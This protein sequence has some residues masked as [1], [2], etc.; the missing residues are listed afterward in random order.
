VSS[1][2]PILARLDTGRALVVGGDPA[3]SLRAR[4]LDLRGPAALGR[5]LRE[6]PSAARD[7]HH[8]EILAGVDVLCCL[9]ADTFPRA[10]QQIGMPFRAAALTGA[11]VELAVEV[12]DAAPRPVLVAG[13]LGTTD[14]PPLPRDRLADELA[15]HAMRLVTAGCEV[16][17]VRASGAGSCEGDGE[18]RAAAI[19][20]AVATR[21]PTWVA[22]PVDGC[23]V[24]A[25]GATADSVASAAFRLGAEVVLLEI[26]AAE[27][28]LGWIDR[29]LA[30]SAAESGHLASQAASAASGA[31][32]RRARHVGFSLAAGTLS[33]E[34]WA[35]DARRLLDAGARVLG[36]G[37]GTTPCHLF[38]LSGL[39][40]ANDRPSPW[41]R[42]V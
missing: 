27:V 23:G 20:S 19:T 38:A 33:P 42:V 32:R 24:A 41:P 7:L 12:A 31:A 39:L 2:N 16:I 28:G 11:A 35:D 26:P 22:V 1:E 3:A 30:L 37:P 14:A 13:V 36:G 34:A 9:T 15:L 5:L 21:L 10:L 25:D 17:L 4:G 40:R 18:A 8:H 6:Q 29:L